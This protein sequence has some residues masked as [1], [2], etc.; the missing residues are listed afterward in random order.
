[1]FHRREK[2]KKYIINNNNYIL[3]ILY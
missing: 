3:N 1:M 2:L